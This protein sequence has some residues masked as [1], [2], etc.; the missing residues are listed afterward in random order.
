ME[1]NNNTD[2]YFRDRLA[3]FEQSPPDSNWDAIA[4]KMSKGKRKLSAL[5]FLR[6]AAGMALITSL[7]IGIYFINQPE[8][9][10]SGKEITER[11]SK[12]EAS[13]IESAEKSPV[14]SILKS[15]EP[16]NHPFEKQKHIQSTTDNTIQNEPSLH[17][18]PE[19]SSEIQNMIPTP[20]TEHIEMNPI[21]SLDI[22]RTL[23]QLPGIDF[24]GSSEK[25]LSQEEAVSLLMAEYNAAFTEDIIDKK[26]NHR[27]ELGG[28]IAPLY[29]DRSINSSSLE[30][31]VIS[32]LND[33]EDG[34]MAYAGGLRVSFSPAR[35]LSVQ[36]G[37]Y[38]SRYGQKKNETLTYNELAT[39]F[40]SNEVVS[41]TNSTGTISMRNQ[42][43]DRYVMNNS[44]NDAGMKE[45]MTQSLLN[46]SSSDEVTIKQTFD[47][48][49]LPLVL[50]YKVIDRKLDFSFSGGIITNFLIGNKVDM[51]QNGRNR[52]IGKTTQ[53][54]EVNYVGSVGLG[55]EYPVIPRFALTLEPRFRYYLNTI[56]QSSQIS[57][58]PYSFGFFAG[59]NYTF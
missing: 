47:Y 16:V 11:T 15:K 10:R 48:F 13:G 58:H 34:I 23:N 53:I 2:R 39:A 45:I 25:N 32:N 29:S 56:D 41:I 57:V 42:G 19:N 30:S 54:N 28:E 31:S 9:S 20:L 50:K 33:K 38:Y 18:V 52:L 55:I 49:E 14:S 40:V 59:V 35:R 5:L 12:P 27:W 44:L 7:G 43:T 36:S 6:I 4:Q 26:T 17:E 46:V 37:V 21:A 1:M 24:S 8:T 3:E 22:P 51:T